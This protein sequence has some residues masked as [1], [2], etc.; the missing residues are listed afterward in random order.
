M[1]MIPCPDCGQEI[2]D[3]AKKCIHCG[4][5]LIEEVKPPKFC[6]ECGREIDN[7]AE[8]CPFCGCP[9]ESEKAENPAVAGIPQ[10]VKKN[11]KHVIIAAAIAAIILAIIMIANL[12]GSFLNQDEQMAYD[13]AV[14]LKSML[15]DP[16]SFRLYD[17]EILII[18]SYEDDKSISSI[19]MIMKYGGANSYGGIVSKQAIFCDGEY[20]MD[21]EDE[22]SGT[23]DDDNFW[24]QTTAKAYIDLCL[25]EGETD[26]REFLFISTE[27]I[28]D[29]MGLNP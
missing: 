25:V 24:A 8:E 28:K 1:A 27:K 6:T 14:E 18:K 2:S 5:V 22:P 23:I 26:Q 4:K 21:Y 9:A 20:I 7:A 16:D 13:A 3:K 29:K 11:K 12:S 17:D 19:Y 15:K 10:T